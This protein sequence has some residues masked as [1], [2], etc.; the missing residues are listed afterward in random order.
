MLEEISILPNLTKDLELER[1]SLGSEGVGE[2]GALNQAIQFL[3]V[4]NYPCLPQSHLEIGSL[5][6]TRSYD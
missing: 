3:K 2:G 5:H 1:R 6:I 4:P